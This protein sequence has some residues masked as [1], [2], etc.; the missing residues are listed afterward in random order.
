MLQD[1]QEY[2]SI[3]NFFRNKL[4]SL[5][6]FTKHRHIELHDDVVTCKSIRTNGDCG[7]C[8]IQQVGGQT[9]TLNNTWMSTFT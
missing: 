8:A 9:H 4:Y 1:Q 3:A 7:P 5:A 2:V 6:D